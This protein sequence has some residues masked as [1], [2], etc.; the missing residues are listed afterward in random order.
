VKR[1]FLE[2]APQGRLPQ[3]QQQQQQ[4]QQQQQQHPP[5]PPSE[6]YNM[7]C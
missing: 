7:F 4:K 2:H 6:H 1:V 5:N 3:Q